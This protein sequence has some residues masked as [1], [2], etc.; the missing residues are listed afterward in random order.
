MEGESTP[1]S[2]IC[3][4]KTVHMTFE[5]CALELTCCHLQELDDRA[6]ERLGFEKELFKCKYH[7]NFANCL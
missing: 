2:V 4:E 7:T 6:K 1:H 3:W 5:H